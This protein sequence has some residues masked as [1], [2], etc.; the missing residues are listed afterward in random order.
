MALPASEPVDENVS[1]LTWQGEYRHDAG[2]KRKEAQ[3]DVF[4]FF[5]CTFFTAAAQ[6][7]RK[8]AG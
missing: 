8:R 6:N 7:I 1:T 2:D 4:A 5:L 3:G